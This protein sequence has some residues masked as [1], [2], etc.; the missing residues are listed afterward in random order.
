MKIYLHLLFFQLLDIVGRLES[1]DLIKYF[2]KVFWAGISQV[3][4][5]FF[6]RIP[7]YFRIVFSFA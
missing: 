7:P 5:N 3:V 6:N 4:S 1:G 2:R